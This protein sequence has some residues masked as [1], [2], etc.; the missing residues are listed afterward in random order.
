MTD[1]ELLAHINALV[2][3]E[4]TLENQPNHT[5]DDRARL[6][7]LQVALEF[8]GNPDEAQERPSDVVEKY[9]Q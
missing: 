4:H 2:N 5:D 7:Q 9:K 8:G 6:Q 1:S 3:E